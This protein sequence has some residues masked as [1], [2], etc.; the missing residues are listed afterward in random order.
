M[1]REKSVKRKKRV[2]RKEKVKKMREKKK[3]RSPTFVAREMSND[4][5]IIAE[6]VLPLASKW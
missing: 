6:P 1:N 3:V 4:W 2:K 5:F